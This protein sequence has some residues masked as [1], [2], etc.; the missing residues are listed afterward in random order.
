[1]TQSIMTLP[2][3]TVIAAHLRPQPAIPA[4]FVLLLT[5]L[6]V[7]IA[8][9]QSEPGMLLAWGI[10]LGLI[11]SAGLALAAGFCSFFPPLAWL[12]L[13]WLGSGPLESLPITAARA[14]L[15][16]GTAVAIA[17]LAIQAWRVI[18]GRFTPTI[19]QHTDPES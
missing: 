14:G 10:P 15:G 3:L 7:R 18:T 2:P 13:A 1:M 6:L 16:V 4:V 19:E 5:G 17:A 11:A 8:A 12:C 9:G